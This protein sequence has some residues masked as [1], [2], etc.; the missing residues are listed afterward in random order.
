MN[1]KKANPK[2]IW[3]GMKRFLQTLCEQN[4]H[5]CNGKHIPMLET[6]GKYPDGRCI[7][8]RDLNK[9]SDK[10]PCKYYI[11]A[12]CQHPQNIKK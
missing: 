12:R 4:G 2:K 3:T 7:F 8:G 11:D 1:M 6:I 10:E 9:T 5:W